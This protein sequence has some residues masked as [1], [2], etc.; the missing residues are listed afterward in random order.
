MLCIRRVPAQPQVPK[1]GRAAVAAL[2]LALAAGPALSAG[3]DPQ[4]PP[5]HFN[6]DVT[7]ACVARAETDEPARSG[8]AVLACPGRAAQ[9]CIARPGQDNTVGMIACLD[10]EWRYWDARL[11]AAY[12]RRIADA[13]KQDAEMA[14][15]RATVEAVEPTLRAMQR[16][17]IAYR[18]A[19]CRHEQAQWLGG[20]GG[21]PA[22]IACHLH[23]TARQALLLEGWW[24]Q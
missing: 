5:A 19:A 23:E 13:R 1:A 2:A 11:N 4:L 10:A 14:T 8:Y 18:D 22:T 6:T 24:R 20:T 15:I 3:A 21:G 16:T 17:W 9:A 7:V 12:A